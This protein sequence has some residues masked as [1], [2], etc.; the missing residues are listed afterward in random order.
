MQVGIIIT[1]FISDE[2]QKDELVQITKDRPWLQN[3]HFSHKV[4]M[5]GIEYVSDDVSIG[6]YLKMYSIHKVYL[7]SPLESNA[8]TK[9]KNCDIN[10]LL[11]F[12]L[13]E[14][15]HTLPRRMY[16]NIKRLFTLPNI[17]PSFEYQYFINRKN[18]Y[19]D[20]FDKLG[21]NVLPF[22]YVS[23]HDFAGD[24][25]LALSKVMS[26]KPGDQGKIIGKPV[27]GQES[28]DFTEFNLVIKIERVEQYLEKM[29][30]TY[31]GVIFQPYIEDFL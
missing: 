7:I 10:I 14:A 13:L 22:V 15:F 12:D 26:M 4:S 16:E 29:F 30:C 20:Y 28:I 18:V 6:Y 17:F 8:Y 21:V 27:F 24:R 3:V 31:N 19:Y 11:I 1:P 25:R 2:I 9:A 5:N 23:K